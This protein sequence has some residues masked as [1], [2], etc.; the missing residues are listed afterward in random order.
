M[1]N[2]INFNGLWL[3]MIL[4]NKYVLF[5]STSHLFCLMVLK[6]FI[7]DSISLSSIKLYKFIYLKTMKIKLFFTYKYCSSK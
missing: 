2:N 1:E 7:Y 6:W 3:D 5:C 4:C